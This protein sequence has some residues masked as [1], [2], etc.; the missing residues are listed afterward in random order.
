M[1]NCLFF[2]HRCISSNSENVDMFAR[3]NWFKDC[4]RQNWFNPHIAVVDPDF[5]DGG[6]TVFMRTSRIF[7]QCAIVADTSLIVVKTMYLL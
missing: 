7:D 1:E 2:F 5:Q 4:P 6:P 3:I